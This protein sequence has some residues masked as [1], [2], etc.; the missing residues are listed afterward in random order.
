MFLLLVTLFFFPSLSIL[1]T[2]VVVVVVVV[3]IVRQWRNTVVILQDFYCTQRF[4]VCTISL[5][6]F[7]GMECFFDWI[8]NVR[9]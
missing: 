8:R 7:F 1:Y 9:W 6:S 4:L 3:V 5:G 2:V